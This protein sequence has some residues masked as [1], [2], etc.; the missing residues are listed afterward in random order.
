[1]AASSIDVHADKQEP[2]SPSHSTL[3]S[4]L[5]SLCFIQINH[6]LKVQGTGLHLLRLVVN[7]A[8]HHSACLSHAYI[9]DS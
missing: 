8:M 3:L 7:L 6:C 1:M 9:I 5:S 2:Q 4:S